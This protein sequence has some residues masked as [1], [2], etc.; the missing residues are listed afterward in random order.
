MNQ[1]TSNI[2]QHHPIT[3]R[4]STIAIPQSL[5]A[6]SDD[7]DGQF[8]TASDPLSLLGHQLTPTS[9]PLSRH[10]QTSQHMDKVGASVGYP[11]TDLKG[12]V[13]DRWK[14]ENL[15]PRNFHVF[16]F[17]SISEH[18]PPSNRR[19]S[20]LTALPHIQREENRE[21]CTFHHDTSR[22]VDESHLSL[23]NNLVP[24]LVRVLGATE[25]KSTSSERRA[26]GNV[27]TLGTDLMPTAKGTSR[28]PKHYSSNVIAREVSNHSDRSPGSFDYQA[29]SEGS[30]VDLPEQNHRRFRSRRN[31]STTHSGNTRKQH[32]DP[33]NMRGISKRLSDLHNAVLINNWIKILESTRPES[34]VI[35]N[36]ADPSF[37]TSTGHD[38]AS[39]TLTAHSRDYQTRIAH[40]DL[41]NF[42]DV[43][44]AALREFDHLKSIR[45]AAAHRP[46]RQVLQGANEVPLVI[47]RK[48]RRKR[49]GGLV[50]PSREQQHGKVISYTRS[51]QVYKDDRGLMNL[52]DVQGLDT[53]GLG[54]AAHPTPHATHPPLHASQ[55]V[56]KQH[57]NGHMG[58]SKVISSSNA[59][60][61]GYQSQMN[62]L[63]FRPP[64][65][66]KDS[67]NVNSLSRSSNRK[68]E[69]ANRPK[70]RGQILAV[71]FS[72]GEIQNLLMQMPSLRAKRA[73]PVQRQARVQG[74]RRALFPFHTAQRSRQ[75]SCYPDLSVS[76]SSMLDM[77][78]LKWQEEMKALVEYALKSRCIWVIDLW[79]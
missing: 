38:N 42:F 3:L 71:D 25:E 11:S 31:L 56:T 44:E 30:D 37:G 22:N 57:E 68:S 79:Q 13:V 6:V 76:G 40:V 62:V 35:K 39:K 52:L 64:K 63:Q 5:F 72:D 58:G 49:P 54:H 41:S 27:V 34:D 15:G 73:G 18:R 26:T 59:S 75:V 8:T 24:D 1:F 12:N 20:K 50:L 33:G 17:N 43:P 61:A 70:V 9:D 47:E 7:L 69:D 67:F 45:Y 10:Q 77:S 16:D 51:P 29:S 53:G 23:N 28:Q 4:D 2:T 78:M 65:T 48:S 36:V 21:E 14:E 46:D 60:T 66:M 32:D 74:Q 19:W 55:I